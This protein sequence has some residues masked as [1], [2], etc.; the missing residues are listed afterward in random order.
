MELSDKYLFP[1]LNQSCQRFMKDDLKTD[2]A[3]V[4]LDDALN[5]NSKE[6]EQKCFE[7]I[8]KQTLKCLE[9][10]SSIEISEK[11]M[12]LILVRDT[13]NAKEIDLF[14]FLLKWGKKEFGS[15]WKDK[16][17]ALLQFI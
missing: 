12:K 13:L 7:L 4:M 5:R 3:L 1:K 17:K 16:I 10:P 2:Y 6:L 11:C 14:R 15:N 9:S 8:D